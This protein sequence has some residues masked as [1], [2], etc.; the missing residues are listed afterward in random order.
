M[1]SWSKRLAQICRLRED[2][3]G[4]TV[5]VASHSRPE[6][7]GHALLKKMVQGGALLRLFQAEVPFGGSLRACSAL[8]AEVLKQNKPQNTTGQGLYPID[9]F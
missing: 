4:Q 1:V 7:S 5:E 2:T 6:C 3:A 9:F 8:S